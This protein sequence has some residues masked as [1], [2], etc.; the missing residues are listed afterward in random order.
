MTMIKNTILGILMLALTA[1]ANADGPWLTSIEEGVKKAKVENK[2]VMIEFTGSDWCPPCM[3][4]AKAVF[5]KEEFLKQAQVD[6]VLV[7]LD[8]PNSD[9]ELKAANQK[10]MKKY[11]ISGVPT[12]LLFDAEGKEFNRF[13]ASE[14]PKVDL[15]IKRLQKE[16]R[17]K[18]MI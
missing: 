11:K 13:T 7:K 12:I 1:V 16:K 2:L 8:M 5:T 10:L 3:M 17:R 6:Y 15:F 18:N 9:K 14:H 4:M